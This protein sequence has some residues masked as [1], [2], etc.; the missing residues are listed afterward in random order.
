MV[1]KGLTRNMKKN[2][3]GYLSISTVT[4]PLGHM[5]SVLAG[6]LLENE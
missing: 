3:H 1:M 6:C 5:R 2:K 4:P